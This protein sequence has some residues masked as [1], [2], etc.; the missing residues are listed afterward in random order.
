MSGGGHSSGFSGG[1]GSSGGGSMFRGNSS[2]GGSVGVPHSGGSRS[3]GS[4]SSHGGNSGNSGLRSPSLGNSSGSM[5]KSSGHGSGQGLSGTQ[6]DRGPR[7]MDFGPSRG[8][9]SGGSGGAHDP[10]FRQG[11]KNLDLGQR[12]IGKSDRV[13]RSGGDRLGDAKQ[14]HEGR[15][16]SDGSSQ[17]GDQKARTT[18]NVRDPVET[19]RHERDRGGDSGLVN[20]DRGGDG[21]RDGR[22]GRGDWDNG[23]G[24]WDGG[25]GDWDNGRNHGGWNGRHSHR[26]NHWHRGFWRLGLWGFNPWWG[27]WGW[28]PGWGGYGFGLGLGYGGWGYGGWGWNS[29]GYSPLWYN[30]GYYGYYNPYCSGPL[31]LGSTVIDYSQPIVVAQ[32][33]TTTP[34][35]EE[36]VDDPATAGAMAEFDAARAAFLNGDYRAALSGVDR[37]LQQIPDDGVLHEFRALVLFAQGDYQQAAATINSV[38]AGGPGWDWET[39][40]GLYPDVP[41]YTAQLRALEAY[42]RAHQTEAFPRFLL[43]YHYLTT[44]YT[45]AAVEQLKR[46]V[47]LQPGDTVAKQLLTSMSPDSQVPAPAPAPASD[48]TLPPQPPVAGDGPAVPPAPPAA[49]E[50]TV[51]RP[52]TTESLVGDWNASREDGS[53]FALTL[54]KEGAF[55]WKYA[56]NGQDNSLKGKYTLAKDLL[57]LE[58]DSGGAM[59]GRLSSAAD[60]QFHFQLVG[61]PPGDPGLTFKQ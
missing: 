10:T 20:N 28:G 47:A 41:T 38:L 60:G 31:V 7:V 26:H 21:W 25:R 53:T 1:K 24:D 22:G 16:G 9:K 15:I 36:A 57:I 14:G 56:G 34:V 18:R 27:G 52:V 11:N 58:P 30:S 17:H 44:G 43:A 55:T 8:G 5:G 12:N 23:R 19:A 54:D 39:L 51:A 42:A 3:G 61:G 48:P 49:E 2:G 40:R 46:V 33:T 45:D 29:W 13:I 6:S 50:H 59:I 32:G 37:A 4:V 35:S